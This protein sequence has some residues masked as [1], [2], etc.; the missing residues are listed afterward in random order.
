MK[1]RSLFGAALAAL[2]LSTAL[3]ACGGAPEA[4]TPIALAKLRS[5][6][7]SS[8]DGE[9][10]GRWLLDEMFAPGGTA[11]GADEA[12]SRLLAKKTSGD[13]LYAALGGAL[14]DESHGDPRRAAR[15]YVAALVHAKKSEDDA[16]P[17]AAWLATHHLVGLRGSVSNLWKDNAAALESVIAAPGRVGWRALAELHEWASAEALDRAEVTGDKYDALVTSRMGCARELR[18]A[19][20]FGR[21]T[22]PDRRRAFAAERAPWPP[23]WPEE[24]SRGSVPHV[25]QTERHRCLTASKEKTD[26]GIFYVETFFDAPTDRDVLVAVQG[27]VAVW[28]DDV[29]VVDRDLRQWGVWQRF[30]GAIRAPKGRHR[31]VARVMNDA[32]SV[33][34]MNLDGTAANLPTDTNASKPYGLARPIAL[35]DPNPISSIVADVAAGRDPGLSPLFVA[36]AAHAAWIDGLSDVASTLME[37]LATPKDAA[38]G[39]LLFAAQYARGDVA[40][41]EQVR[42]ISEKE[43]YTRALTADPGLWYAR[44][45]ILLDDAD[46]RGLV[47]AVEPLRKLAADLPN[48]PQ[49]TEQLARVYGRLGWRAERM[50]AVKDLSARFPDD[51]EAL[52]LYLT[53]LEDDG[54]LAEADEVAARIRTL[55]PDAEVDLDRALARR[56]WKE[57]IAELRRLE[58]RRPDRKEIAGRIADVL[59]RSGDPSAAAAQLEKALAKNPADVQARFRLADHAYARGDTSALR[60]A[61][62]EALQAGSKGIEIREAVEILEGASLLE[63]YRQDGRKVIREFEAW[64]KSGKHMD[65][66]AARVL[67]Y[68]AV[69]V[70]S[71][72]SSEMLEHEIVRMQS[73][74]AVDKES[75][76]KPPD[77]LVLRLRVIKPDGS[78]LEPEPV[79][80]KPTL[81]MPH[82]EVGDYVEMEHITAFA[83]DGA[84]GRRYRGPHWFFR[85]ADKGYWRS[86]FVVMAPKDRPVEIETVGQVPQPKTAERGPFLERRW[87]VDE[88][89]PAP[90]EPDAPNPR[91]F[92]PSVRVGWGIDL[93]DTLLRYVDAASEETPLDPRL[94]K[95]AQAIVKDIP[96]TKKDDR[97]RAIYTFVGETVQDAQESDGRRVITGRAGSRQAAF[98]YLTRLLGIKV[99]LALV[100]SRIA[101]PPAGKMSEVEIYDN[102]VAR[103][104]TGGDG[105][106]LTVRDKFAPFGYVPAE[107][108]GQPAIRLVPGTPRATTPR[109]GAAD[110]VL[111]AGRASL[112]EDGSASVEITQSYVGRMGI[113]LRAVFDR[114]AEGKRSEFV[115]TRLL[116]NNLPGARLKELRMENKDDLAAPL[117]LKMKADVPQLARRASG[118]KLLLKQ[119]FAVDIAQIASL[120]Q[121]QTPLLLG[122][123]SHVEVD[124]EIVTPAT[125]RL[126]GS[127]PGG[128][129]RDGDRSVV[130][131]DTVEGNALKLVRVVD[132]PA[133]RV[134]PGA[135]Y[136]RFV[137]FTQSADELLAREI[138]LGE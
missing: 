126:P 21:G 72:G 6:G 52:G 15:G 78:I 38:P 30:G 12:R 96:E 108:R 25:L 53:A 94:V 33:R 79:A 55:D 37:P 99:E 122:S 44:A 47:E 26:D 111:I 84:K 48:V 70:H 119:L 117:V 68:A 129:L 89:P 62:A 80:G 124:F 135:D 16:A 121:R 17:L 81:T 27:A 85:E 125:M 66:N 24:P 103:L 77:G 32:A 60:R 5:Q 69:W 28:V 138:A 82:L 101:M 130:V 95:V 87:R 7:R 112:K 133:G 93:E 42:R 102:V 4:R 20:P 31:V 109:L 3:G 13:A 40:F 46:Q 34:L 41:T 73:Q 18:I 22:A 54:A 120:P 74:E 9:V 134:Q 19:G 58:K 63:P 2:A 65:G 118:G 23:S 61:L 76:Q 11:K 131:K 97:A 45:W 67:D 113:G 92:L 91:E 57:A 132:I 127:L 59:M 83:S 114:V 123:S 51:R 64:E 88:S 75:E 10:V 98:F 137:Q 107:L 36:L 110:G 1:R 71:D 43:L 105:R 29:P 136:A 128:A 14:Y 8:S 86:E 49:I 115:E 116:G 106:W 50:R 104:E 90:E 39:A 100:K 56:D 35:P